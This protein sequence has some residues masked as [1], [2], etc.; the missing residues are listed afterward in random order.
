MYVRLGLANPKEGMAE[1]A[2]NYFR[3]V[4]IPVY[5]QVSG[6]LGAACYINNEG[7]LMA[8]TTWANNEAKEAAMA[9]FQQNL[10]GLAELLNEPPTIL[11]GPM[12]AG[13]QYIMVPK[14][15][16]EPFFARFVMGGGTQEGKTYDDIADFMTNTVYTAYEN[17]EGI[18]ATGA[19]KIDENSGFSF[20]FWTSHDAAHAASEVISSVVS[21][22]V[23]SLIKEAPKELTGECNVWKNYVDFPVGKI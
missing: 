15:G 17:V 9:E 10:A 20:N 23:A 16:E 11:E 12:V 22:A 6:L 8:W 3:D 21:D 1:D 4:A 13:Q 5:D 19:C 7:Q 2:L 14:D 18:Y